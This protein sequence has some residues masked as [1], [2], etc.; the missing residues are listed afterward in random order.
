M[1]EAS[2]Q[3]LT[4]PRKPMADYKLHDAQ[5][6]AH[7]AMADALDDDHLAI[8]CARG[9]EY[10]ISVYDTPD[11]LDGENYGVAI[12]CVN[13]DN[14]VVWSAGTTIGTDTRI[15]DAVRAARKSSNL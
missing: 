3:T 2:R 12:T 9:C 10:Q 1:K 6:N 13:G 7:N 11:M 8:Y 15:I 14:D 4:Q 5:D